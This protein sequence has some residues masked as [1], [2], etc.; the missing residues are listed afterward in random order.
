MNNR[1]D[2]MT[3]TDAESLRTAHD[4]L[5]NPGWVAR[6]SNMVGQPIEKGLSHLPEK[7]S[8]AIGD[9]VQKAIHASLKVALRTMDYND[10]STTE[11]PKASK[12]W[13]MAASAAS[14]AV[15]GAF[16][17]GAIA[18]ELPVS[19]TIMM[20]SIADIARSEGADLA[21]VETQLECIQVLAFGGKSRKDDAAGIGYFAAR[22]AMAKAVADAAK[23]L[24]TKGLSEPGAPALVRFIAVIAERYGVVVGDKAAAQLVPV[25]GAIGGAAINT[26]F[27]DHFQ[28]M[29]KGHFT[30]RRLERK[31][32]GDLVQAEY[33]ELS[34]RS[35]GSSA[36]D[37][38]AVVE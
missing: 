10:P 19:T 27:M 9:A 31:Y 28:D 7:A 35:L 2:L 23:H 34:R 1:L 3:D 33:R 5:E 13:H 24:A 18:V 30:V 11:P 4:L 22:E 29:A 6:L 26:A 20:R 36:H 12:W 37:S 25:I 15:G 38:A 32:G 8:A 16:G 21:D 14:G 17:I